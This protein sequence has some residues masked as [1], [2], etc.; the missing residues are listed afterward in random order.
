MAIKITKQCIR[1]IILKKKGLHSIIILHQYHCLNSL[2]IPAFMNNNFLW[3]TWSWAF[4]TRTDAFVCVWYSACHFEQRGEGLNIHRWWRYLKGI[5]NQELP[6]KILAGCCN[7]I[8]MFFIPLYKCKFSIG[9]AEGQVF[10]S[11]EKSYLFLFCPLWLI[12]L[13]EY[14]IFTAVDGKSLK[15]ISPFSCI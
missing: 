13:Q 11:G 8:P 14:L 2:L 5:L 15:K 10:Q 12:F 1:F 7:R 3:S 4:C 6:D 9:S